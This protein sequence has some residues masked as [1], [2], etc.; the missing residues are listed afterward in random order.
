ML[1]KKS[2]KSGLRKSPIERNWEIILNLPLQKGDFK[3]PPLWKRWGAGEVYFDI[4]LGSKQGGYNS[5]A[6]YVKIE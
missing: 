5:E 3:F 6:G 4:T 1:S 2:S